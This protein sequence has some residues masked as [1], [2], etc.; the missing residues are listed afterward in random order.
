VAGPGTGA[1]G[2]MG[3]GGG[4]VKAGRGRWGVLP[5]GHQVLRDVEEEPAR[6]AWGELAAEGALLH[7]RDPQA[8]LGAR[9][10]H[11]EEPPLLL[12]ADRAVGGRHVGRALGHRARVGEQALLAADDEHVGELEPLG[13]VH[14]GQ[15]DLVLDLLLVLLLAEGEDAREIDRRRAEITAR[16][17][18]QRA[19]R[20]HLVPVVRSFKVRGWVDFWLALAYGW[21]I[22]WFLA[23]KLIEHV[24]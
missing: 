8:I 1:R 11:V 6:H 14:R 19:T 22:A 13:A 18:E 24:A 16:R 12:D 5:H 15:G 3:G 23:G 20:A 17:R 4:G 9:D 10:R 2:L 21:S 7:T